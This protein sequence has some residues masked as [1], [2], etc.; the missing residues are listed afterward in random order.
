METLTWTQR[1]NIEKAKIIQWIKRAF[2]SE[3]VNLQRIAVA[4]GTLF[5]IVKEFP[6]KYPKLLN[7]LI[8]LIYFLIVASL[9]AYL[10][11]L[12]ETSTAKIASEAR[13]TLGVG[14]VWDYIMHYL[15][16]PFE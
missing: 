2:S 16:L 6:R 5:A 10:M 11:F 7:S 13:Y 4:F 3:S 1:F 12:A 8:K 9:F 14:G 15:R